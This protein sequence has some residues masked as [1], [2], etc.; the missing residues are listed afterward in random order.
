[1]LWS[2]CGEQPASKAGQIFPE[3]ALVH[4]A[5]GQPANLAQYRGKALLVNFW[6]TWCEPCRKEMPALEALSRS[7]DSD[8]AAVIGVSVDT[9]L[10]LAREFVRKYS[11]SFNQFADPGM[12]RTRALLRTDALPVTY[13]VASDGTLVVRHIG[14]RDWSQQAARLELEAAH[15]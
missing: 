3:L 11:L 13:I 8:R 14:A 15:R 10:N 2:G 9:D 5:D 4:L 6:A 1:V 12:T 7:V